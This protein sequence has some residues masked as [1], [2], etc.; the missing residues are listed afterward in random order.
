MSL[1]V[2]TL[3]FSLSALGVFLTVHRY[4]PTL[5]GQND[6]QHHPIRSTSIYSNAKKLRAA[7]SF[8]SLKKVARSAFSNNSP[9]QHTKDRLLL[10][11]F[12]VNA[13]VSTT[14]TAS[15]VVVELVLCEIC[16]WLDPTARVL[17]WKTCTTVLLSML[18]VVIPILEV[19]LW[20]YSSSSALITRFKYPLTLT[21]FLTWLFIFSKMGNFIPLPPDASAFASISSVY[22]SP[23]A[24]RSFAEETLSR[25]VVI[26]VCAMAILSGFAAVSTP[27][28]VFISSPRTVNVHDMERI[29][30]S[31]ESTANLI[32]T[33]ELELNIV[34]NKIRDRQFMS[35]TNLRSK[36]LSSIRASVGGGDELTEEFQTLGMELHGLKSMRDSLANDLRTV[37]DAYS[38]QVAD[39]T[40][41]GRLMRKA[42]FIF[43][44]YCIYRLIT[45]L[46]LRNPI[47]RAHTLISLS[48]S[49]RPSDSGSSVPETTSIA[50]S[51]ALAITIA[52]IAVK[53]SSYSD[54]EAWT[55]QIGF[56]LSGF[57][58]M[59]SISSAL[60]T[61]N[62]IAKAFPFL[63]QE[64][65]LHI[66]SA[67]TG[68]ADAYTGIGLLLV[69]QVSAIYI[70]STSLLLR[71]NLPKEMSS[72]I[73]AALGAPLDTVFVESLFDTFFSLVA[74][75]SLLS[76]WLAHRYKLG[77]EEYLYDEESL[78]DSNGK[79]A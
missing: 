65:L 27:Y 1:V 70:L 73:T 54:V 19:F 40:P 53:F 38:A 57:L 10:H 31:L 18:V 45:V 23:V 35:S 61:F 28:T 36:I 48:M 8:N 62:S 77:D 17:V 58:F 12:L 50:Q 9:H 42:Y 20:L 68:S 32:H 44:L 78:L 22:W 34:Q 30:N 21:I 69:A 59:G 46:L 72:A 39:K 3:P 55:R 37:Q 33:K 64:N 79:L 41:L 52:H 6:P 76:L 43:A 63:K 47:S 14:I 5:Q 15:F 7:L 29:Q 60:S 4:L 56:I 26:G 11:Q 25:I 67:I 16:N 66:S 75:V 71:S 13:S 24:R 51:D 2:N 74:I 49:R